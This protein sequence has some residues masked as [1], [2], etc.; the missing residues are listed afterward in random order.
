MNGLSMAVAQYQI[1]NIADEQLNAEERSH[2]PV[3]ICFSNIAVLHD[4][5]TGDVA[6]ANA[7]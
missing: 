2:E 3:P 1:R 6:R 4:R 5:R 7:R